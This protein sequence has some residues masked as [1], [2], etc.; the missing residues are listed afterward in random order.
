MRILVA[1]ADFHA[2]RWPQG[3][4]DDAGSGGWLFPSGVRTSAGSVCGGVVVVRL[5]NYM[6]VV[7]S[8][9]SI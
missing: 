3:R 6:Y 9:A 7:S 2:A 4:R 1:N 5:L 8:V